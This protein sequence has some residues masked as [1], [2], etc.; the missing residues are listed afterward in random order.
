[1]FGIRDAFLSIFARNSRFGNQR[2]EKSIPS[3][4]RTLYT[5]FCLKK[6]FSFGLFT[7]LVSF[8]LQPPIEFLQH[9][10]LCTS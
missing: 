4:T 9:E 2:V 5:S 3:H 1:M 6:K 7:F 8:F 10:S